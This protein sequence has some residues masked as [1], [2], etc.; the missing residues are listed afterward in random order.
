MFI[1]SSD[2]VKIFFWMQFAKSP[3]RYGNSR[4]IWNHTVLPATRQTW[5]SRLYSAKLVLD[6]VTSKGCRA[7]L[8]KYSNCN[9]LLSFITCFHCNLDIYAC[10]VYV[11]Y[12]RIQIYLL[13]C[14]YCPEAGDAVNSS[15]K[16]ACGE[17]CLRASE[18]H[19]YSLVAAYHS[20][21]GDHRRM[22]PL[23]S[24]YPNNTHEPTSS[25]QT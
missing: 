16:L 17:T 25:K 10:R 1:N 5:H 18:L 7:K 6:L 2:F 8:T 23:P 15:R 19:S 3:H 12:R 22:R 9:Q 21:I 11:K 20:Q 14:S 4:A 24:L 13:N